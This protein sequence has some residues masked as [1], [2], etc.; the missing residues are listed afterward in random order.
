MGSISGRENSE[1]EIQ[2]EN[3]S[4][5]QK[6]QNKVKPRYQSNGEESRQGKKDRHASKGI[7]NERVLLRTVCVCLYIQ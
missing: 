6:T 2:S 4:V 7:W 5:I 1:R 3:T